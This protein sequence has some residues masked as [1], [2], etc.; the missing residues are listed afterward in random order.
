MSA[1]R[2]SR[3]SAD[4]NSCGN[5]RGRF[6]RR[7]RRTPRSKSIEGD[8]ATGGNRPGA[9]A[10]PVPKPKQPHT[11]RGISPA[12]RFRRTG[13]S[14]TR[15]RG[16]RRIQTTTKTGSGDVRALWLEV[17]VVTGLPNSGSNRGQ[18]SPG[19]S[20]PDRQ[21]EHKADPSSLPN[22]G[23]SGLS[24]VRSDAGNSGNHPATNGA[25]SEPPDVS[26]AFKSE[27]AA[28]RGYYAARIAAARRNLRAGDLA[29]AIRALLNEETVA[30]RAVTERWKAATERQEQEKPQRPTG[31]VQRKDDPKPL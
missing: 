26:P 19:L 8:S 22:D 1:M 16:R 20:E 7:Q 23:T 25:P 30:L 21:Q 31:N 18:S 28:I 12:R 2:L 27:M 29:V 9:G 3:R 11:K 24:G 5:C 6:H 4:R 14:L 10:A 15:W 17:R 13:R